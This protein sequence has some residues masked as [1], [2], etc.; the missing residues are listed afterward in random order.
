MKSGHPDTV[1]YSL[2]IP[3]EASLTYLAEDTGENSE[4]SLVIPE[5]NDQFGSFSMRVNLPDGSEIH[6]PVYQGAEDNMSVRNE[7]GIIKEQKMQDPCV[8]AEHD[9]GLY[10][11]KIPVSLLP[12]LDELLPSSPNPVKDF[13]KDSYDSQQISYERTHHSKL[14]VFEPFTMQTPDLIPNL[15]IFYGSIDTS[16]NENMTLP[17]FGL[18]NSVSSQDQEMYAQDMGLIIDNPSSIDES[19]VSI[20]NLPSGSPEEKKEDNS[21]SLCNPR[22]EKLDD[23]PKSADRKK[24][25]DVSVMR[26]KPQYL[27]LDM[28]GTV[29]QQFPQNFIHSHGKR[30]TTS[31]TISTSV[32]YPS[33]QNGSAFVNDT[34]IFAQQDREYKGLNI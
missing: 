24:R 11:A 6:D 17:N 33:S 27:T 4:M 7:H 1:L 26:K 12:K 25:P 16:D 20:E 18:I 28:S 9:K 13:F 30:E 14:E 15:S 5:L 8:T 10:S 2:I 34:D 29:Q 31:S 23:L 32:G 19:I 21:L 22:E 3:Q